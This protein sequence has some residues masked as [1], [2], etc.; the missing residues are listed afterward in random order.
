[1][2]PRPSTGI[3]SREQLI[4]ALVEVAEIE[5]VLMCQY[6]FAGFSMKTDPSEFP[7][8]AR[9]H[10]QSELTRRWKRMILRVAREEMQHLAYATNLLVSV[11]GAP[12]FQRPNFPNSNRFFRKD[13]RS[14]ALVMSLERFDPQGRTIRR[15]V[16][17]ETDDPEAHP[18][19]RG[20]GAGVPRPN[21][22]QTLS[23]FYGAIREAFT[24]SMFVARGR[25]YDPVNE[26]GESVRL[27]RHRHVPN[28]V[29]TVDE[30]RALIDLIVLQGEGATSTD[31]E[32]H[33][34]IF[35]AIERELEDERAV[36][37]AFDPSRPVVSNPL[38][39]LHN[40][41]RDDIDSAT[42][43]PGDRDG[44]LQHDLL[45]LFNGAYEVSLCWLHQLFSR[46]GNA[47]EL[48]AIETL[49]FLPL[50]SEVIRPIGELLTLVPI[51]VRWPTEERLG[52]SFEV[53]ANTFLVPGADV[54]P[55]LTE[56]K[57]EWLVEQARRSAVAC[58]AVGLDRA[59]RD[60]EP[61]VL[62]LTL[63]REEYL[64]RIDRG[65]PPR[66]VP[67]SSDTAYAEDPAEVPVDPMTPTLELEFH[68]W[69]QIRLA[70]D[71]DPS[72]C[73]RGCTGNAFAIGD[74]PDLD[75]VIR[76]QPARTVRR[77][78]CP[79]VGVR[80]VAARLLASPLQAV[81]E[82]QPVPLLVGAAVDLVGEPKFEGRNHLVS[83][84]GEPID[85][86]EIEV[87]SDDGM[88]LRR[89][90][91]GNPLVQM[92]PPQR[93][94]TGR[95]PVSLGLNI[96]AMRD[97]MRRAG[98]GVSLP[99]YVAARITAIEQELSRM[100]PAERSGGLAAGLEFRRDVLREARPGHI[101][102]SR[103]L[104]EARYA[105]T[106]SGEMKASLPGISP[107]FSIREPAR[108]DAAKWLVT[109]AFGFYDTDS[110]NAFVQGTI[111]IPVEMHT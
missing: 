27:R 55:M 75:R 81:E 36:D 67:G 84:D 89:R 5:H 6:L 31:P 2:T 93:R 14:R 107:S 50:M 18:G 88:V 109:Y 98:I 54:S 47:A 53:T 74:E 94:G 108:G 91:V 58:A 35:R 73:R 22:Y 28:V 60:L 97:R 12:S 86:F 111:R 79:E 70:S 72:D 83:E 25:Q 37:P 110:L 90:V 96:P 21:Y 64:S 71:P 100:P 19:R 23:E 49:A 24:P 9:R 101:R 40:D 8:E 13:S 106:V 34:Q 32:A 104:L 3:D 68:G 59:A 82:W 15:F 41:I 95:Y 33:L 57:L 76:F 78:H 45:Q 61:I 66:P 56:Q 30:A 87:R 42:V 48:R 43:I 17:F 7:N 105:H 77:S 80:V 16:R 29:R 85:P 46:Q 26:D 99:E 102:W 65:W 1:M 52:A 39:R 63:L 4:S 10:R 11:G 20:R 92:S 62:S 103:F 69:A 44:G 38:T 51:D